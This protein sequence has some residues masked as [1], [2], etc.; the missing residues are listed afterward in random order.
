M[1]EWTGHEPYHVR[2]L[3]IA[4]QDEIIQTLTYIHESIVREKPGP[5]SRYLRHADVEES[6]DSHSVSGIWDEEL[7][8]QREY[9][10]R[11]SATTRRLWRRMR[12][13]RCGGSRL[14]RVK[15]KVNYEAKAIRVGWGWVIAGSRIRRVPYQVWVTYFFKTDHPPD[16]TS[17]AAYVFGSGSNVPSVCC[18]LGKINVAG[19]VPGGRT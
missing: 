9:P 12:W 7:L 16:L 1:R 4:T 8:K 5:F 11:N 10:P 18:T 17:G 19:R 6:F 15:H 3:R 13:V 14:R 2:F